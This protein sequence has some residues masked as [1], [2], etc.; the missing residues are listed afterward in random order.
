MI[1]PNAVC[2]VY[3]AITSNRPYKSGWNPAESIRRMA[4]CTRGH[5]D[6]TVFQAFVKTVGIYPVGSLVPM[7]SGRLGV[8]VEQIEGALLT[9]KVKLFFSTKSQ[10]HILPE[11]ID[12]SR[13]GTADGIAS[14]EDPERWRLARVDEIWAGEAAA[15]RT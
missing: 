2:D 6:E 11:T 12:L 3:D 7:E 13:P 15:R 1:A 8:V 10:L 5:F 9:P 14:R 4:E